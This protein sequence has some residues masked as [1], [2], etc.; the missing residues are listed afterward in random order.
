MRL[1]LSIN[2]AL[3]LVMIVACVAYAG[4][5]RR[6]AEA[7][8]SEKIIAANAPIIPSAAHALQMSDSAHR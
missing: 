5:A 7:A 6:K 2:A 3:A 1:S 4:Y 8:L